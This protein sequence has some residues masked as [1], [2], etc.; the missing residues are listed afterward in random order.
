MGEGDARGREGTIVSL[1]SEFKE[2]IQRGNV[3]DLAIAVVLG[4]SFGRVVT[5]FVDDVL[6]PPIGMLL[7]GTDFSNLFYSLDG[8]TYP[9]LAVAR[10]AGAPAIAYGAFLNTA[11][12]FLIVAFAVFLVV[13][14][15]NH[16]RKQEAATVAC[17][18]CDTQ[19]SVKAVKCP[20]CTS[21]VKGGPAIT[22]APE[23]QAAPTRRRE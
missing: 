21:A 14:A 4:A 13:K 20:S 3:I 18:Y 10:A 22:F 17:P 9:S 7:G 12:Q 5:S 16:F 19:I 11:I 2:F 6:M 23:G 15:F 8:V 1:V